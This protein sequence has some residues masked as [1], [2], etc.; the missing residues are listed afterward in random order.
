MH[1]KQCFLNFLAAWYI[2]W[3]KNVYEDEKLWLKM[4]C[5]DLTSIF[6][7]DIF[8]IKPGTHAM[9]IP[10]V[11]LIWAMYMPAVNVICFQMFS[12]AWWRHQIETFSALLAVCAGNSPVS[13]EFPT[14]RPV[15]QSFDV[16]FD[17]RPN[18]R[19]S[20]QWR[21]WWF[22]TPSCPLWC[23]CNGCGRYT[24]DEMYAIFEGNTSPS[25]CYKEL[26]FCVT[27]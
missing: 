14:Q 19:L 9:H 7:Q 8:I 10:A 23:H 25:L 16:F 26:A 1:L 12:D 21:G 17:L 3:S 6:W 27:M 18:K 13:D 4:C 11:D 2:I 5:V 22:E 20:K 15:T 24:S